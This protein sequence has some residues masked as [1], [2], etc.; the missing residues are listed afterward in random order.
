VVPGLPVVLV[1]E[2]AVE[3]VACMPAFGTTFAAPV[4]LACVAT[5]L[6]GREVV[7]GLE[8]TCETVLDVAV[9]AGGA[10]F[11]WVAGTA[12]AVLVDW[13]AGVGRGATRAPPPSMSWS[14]ANATA[15]VLALAGPNFSVF[16][17]VCWVPRY[18]R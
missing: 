13:A 4:P 12:A 9:A 14:T 17:L 8:A 10:L 18:G 5:G 1:L 16:G 6:V 2:V 11:A 3:P 7:V 15:A